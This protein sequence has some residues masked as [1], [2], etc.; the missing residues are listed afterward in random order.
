MRSRFIAAA[1]A[2]IILF[3]LSC[4]DQQLDRSAPTAPLA[5]KGGA[6]LKS[7]SVTPSASSVNIG[8]SVQLTATATPGS[9]SPTYVWTSSNPS[10][11]TVTQSG[12]VSGVG[13]GSAT[14]TAGASGVSGAAT[15]TVV[16]P[17]ADPVLVGA[18]DI[19][20]CTSSGDE[21]TAKLL[22]GIP[23]TVFTLGDN[24]YESG[25]TTEYNNC[26]GPS[27]GRHKARTQPTPGNHEY[28]TANASG[29]YGYFGGLAGDPTKGYYSYTLGQWHVIVLNSNSD[30][31]AISCA[32]GSAQEQWLRAD[33]AAHPTTCTLAYWHHPLFSFSTESGPSPSV[34]PLWRVLS[35]A[36]VDVVV[37]GHSHNYQRWAP[38][39]PGGHASST[40]IREFVVGTGG[41]SHYA[42]QD[43]PWPEN[44]VAG[45]TDAFGVLR[46]A[47]K[48]EGYRW[49]WVSA[50]GQPAFDDT[51]PRTVPCH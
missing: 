13:V 43:G 42:F 46:L 19:A 24:A 16:D 39:T 17:S 1:S 48:A 7:I 45:Q 18:G 2:A 21:A 6:K 29:Y 32:A 49:Q 11:A 36:G 38:Q 50:R 23:G 30:C 35:R 5:A 51:S 40:G 28:N 8:Q 15:V 20:S 34:R 33:L 9:V 47:L 41:A 31:G 37:N 44:L 26:Y 14:I 25:T 3:A 12:L 27:W 10:V 22:D 4:F